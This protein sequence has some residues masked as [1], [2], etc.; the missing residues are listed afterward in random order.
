MALGDLIARLERDAE[1]RV[2]ELKAK[3]DAE[4]AALEAEAARVRDARRGEELTSRRA[5]RRLRFEQALA[6]ARQRARADRLRAEHALLARVFERARVELATVARTPAYA[7]ALEGHLA[8]A[9]EYLQGQRVVVR[10]APEFAARLAPALDARGDAALVEDAALGPG[11]VVTAADDS[12]VIDQTLAARLARLEPQLGVE[13][14]SALQQ[15]RG[16]GS[17]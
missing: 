7:A 8:E 10:C 4:V 13:L 11:V 12:V 9:L 16:G 14:L 5:A 2:A 1:R 15:E 17:P 6:D 3:A